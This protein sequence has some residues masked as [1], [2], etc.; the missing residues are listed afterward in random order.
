MAKLAGVPSSVESRAREI[1]K[2]LEQR[3][4]LR[5]EKAEEKTSQEEQWHSN[6]REAT[7]VNCELSSSSPD[8]SSKKDTLPESEVT[9]ALLL[10]TPESITPREA[11]DIIYDLH[12]KAK[13]GS[14]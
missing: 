14:Q 7:L 13:A 4:S 10:L 1:L 9:K 3:E 12:S 5:E 6:T 8:T 11:L 2:S